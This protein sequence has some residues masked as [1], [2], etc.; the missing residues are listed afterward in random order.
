M[1]CSEEKPR[2]RQRPWGQCPP[3]D[4]GG[5]NLNDE[6]EE[7]RNSDAG[8]APLPAESGLLDEQHLSAP[9]SPLL[10]L[11][12]LFFRPSRFFRS[13]AVKPAPVLTV[14]C[15]WTFGIDAVIG[16]MEVKS[17]L[18]RADMFLESWAA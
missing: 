6:G 3:D 18:G 15:G 13:F 9:P 16:R 17:A 8:G 1:V 14:L 4:L 10:W 7:T 11:P 5:R 12:Y 2:P